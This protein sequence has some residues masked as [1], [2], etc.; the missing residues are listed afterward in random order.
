MSGWRRR[1]FE[2]RR[3]SGSARGLDVAAFETKH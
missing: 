1:R 2:S 3:H